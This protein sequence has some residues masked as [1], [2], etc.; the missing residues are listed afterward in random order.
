VSRLERTEASG[1]PDLPQAD[2]EGLILSAIPALRQVSVEVRS[3]VSAAMT[4]KSFGFGEVLVRSGEA[5]DAMYIIVSGGVRVVG[6][7]GSGGEVVLATMHA[8]DVLGE[9]ALGVQETR[10]ATVRATEPTE[11][12]RLDSGVARALAASEPAVQRAFELVSSA[13]RVRDVLRLASPFRNVSAGAMEELSSS[14]RDVIAPKGESVYRQGDP[15]GPMFVVASGKLRAHRS[16]EGTDD[17]IGYLQRGDCFGEAAALFGEARSHSVTALV[18]CEL[19]ALDPECLVQ[20]VRS[21]PELRAVLDGHLE[22]LEYAGKARVP[23]DFAEEILPAGARA[24]TDLAVTK[25]TFHSGSPRTLGGG[26]GAEIPTREEPTTD[27]EGSDVFARF[28]APRRRRGRIPH[29]F[30]IDESDCGAACLAIVCRYYGRRVP[31]RVVREAIGVRARGASLAALK[32]G[33]EQLGLHCAMVKVPSTML[34]RIPLPAVVNWKARHWMVLYDVGDRSVRVA[35]PATGIRKMPRSEFVDGWNGFATVHEAT[36]QLDEISE[37]RRDIGWL[38]PFVAP[39][40][41]QLAGALAL[42]L[43]ASFAQL[44]IPLLI[45]LVVDTA[46]PKHNRTLLVAAFLAMLAAVVVMMGASIAQ[47]YLFAKAVVQI[48][49]GASDHLN[50]R[51]LSLPAAYFSTRSTG[52]ITNRLEGVRSLRDFLVQSGVEAA[53]AAITL[54]AIV[55]LMAVYNILLAL[56][57]VAVAPAYVATLRVWRRHIRP[58]AA[59]LQ[60]SEG[61]YSAIQVDAVK[62]IETIK[63]LSAERTVRDYLAFKRTSLSQRRFRV[64][65]GGMIYQSA[66]LALGTVVLALFLFIGSLQV[67]GHNLELGSFVAFIA[68]VLLASSPVSTLMLT[69]ELLE[70]RGILLDR[71]DDVLRPEPEQ[72][73]DHSNLRPVPTLSGRIHLHDIGFS[74]PGP[75]PVPVIENIELHVEPRQVVAIVGRSGSGKSTLAK[76]LAG[77]IAPT[78]GHIYYDGIDMQALDFGQLRRNIGL[79]LQHSYIFD[80]PIANNIALGDLSPDPEAVRDAAAIADAHGF[81]SRL[82]LGYET[83]IGERGIKLSGGQAQRIS[84]ARAIY[85]DPPVLVFDEATSALDAETEHTVLANLTTLI[86]GRTTFIIAHRLS[87]IRDADVIVV[88]D[89]GQMVEVGSHEELIAKRG[90]YY[91][92]TNRQLLP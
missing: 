62:G 44:S 12:L 45:P 74:Y 29:V 61:E 77:L 72:G 40:R 2:A 53:S 4:L 90:V 80:A 5:A 16:R 7:D 27:V 67:L 54:V 20:L 78:T 64:E 91:A 32:S 48:D 73:T 59:N 22:Q 70:Y 37:E 68:L 6:D 65:L 89:H 92:L 83:H 21:F 41:P 8:G 18:D 63:A 66:S 1:P 81:I 23:L 3:L 10:T 38:R 30:Q 25:G 79:V 46:I 57:F 28:G 58:V 75:R 47:R 42:S 14:V 43:V 11:A 87:T 36:E 17:D 85:R 52:D 15:A 35:D 9:T 71:L 51:L 33:A 88:L 82:P 24:L 34:D 13:R 19:L 76:C 49:I 60:E 50:E 39:W 56:I 26:A 69:W 55:V 31:L 84:I 86:D